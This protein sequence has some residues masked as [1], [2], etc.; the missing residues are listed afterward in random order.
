L[1]IFAGVVF[2]GFLELMKKEKH[3]IAFILLIISAWLFYGA[4]SCFVASL[5]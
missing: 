2:Y 4:I 5:C 3:P 1:F